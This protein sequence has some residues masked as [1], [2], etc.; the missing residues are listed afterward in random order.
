MGV[1]V[2]VVAAVVLVWICL[3]H[4]PGDLELVELL[5]AQ[6]QSLGTREVRKLPGSELDRI[7]SDHYR[8][9]TGIDD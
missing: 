5:E 2:P 3:R 1:V 8:V 9:R 7:P 4:R 6:I